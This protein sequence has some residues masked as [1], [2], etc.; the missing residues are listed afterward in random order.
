MK[1]LFAKQT[2]M[3]SRC[4]LSKRFTSLVQ[5]RPVSNSRWVSTAD[6]E[7]AEK[8][9]NNEKLYDH[10]IPTSMLQKLILAGGSALVGLADPWRADMVA[11]S[12][13]VTASPAALRALRDKMLACDEGRVVLE[14]RPRITSSILTNLAALPPNTLGFRYQAFLTK[15]DIT[16][17]SRAEVSFVDCP[18]LA[19]VMTRY[20]ETHDLTHCIL[21][22]PTT[23]V[24]EVAVKWVE[25][26]Q[27]GLPMCVGGAVLGPLRFGAKQREQYE[28]VMPWAVEIG[29]KASFLLAVHW[30]NRW[31]QDFEQLQR[32]LGITPA[33]RFL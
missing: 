22:M 26:L 10:H 25:A 31:E 30:E 17:D 16:P 24:G 19:Y 11:V 12:G 6:G 15:H 18:D 32:E 33:P 2:K 29:N 9:E 21:G 23:M 4:I 20:R 14:T 28:K 7:Q 13:E 3:A 27:L 1:R 5:L 8:T